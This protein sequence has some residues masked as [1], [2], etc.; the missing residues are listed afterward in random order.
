MEPRFSNRRE[1]GQVLA[2]KLLRYVGKHDVTVLALPRGGVPVAFEIARTLRA[3][4]DVFL[5]RT[6]RLSGH[7]G[8]ALG[9][10]A[11]G[12]VRLLD[13]DAVRRIP[14]AALEAVARSERQE[15][16]R[17]ERLYRGHRWRRTLRGRTIILVDDGLASGSGMR[18]TLAALRSQRVARVVVAVPVASPDAFR[19]L[20]GQA[21]ELVCTVASAPFQAVALWYDDFPQTS[22]LE[23][24][25]LLEKARGRSSWSLS[26]H[27]S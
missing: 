23:V 26:R 6:L 15:L 20:S 9:V 11:S 1:A 12:G 25:G 19:E 17:R 27:A 3:P 2:G 8:P 10:I 13:E 14:H 16:E 18:A 7:D 4:L 21:D 5:V 24:Q 22:D